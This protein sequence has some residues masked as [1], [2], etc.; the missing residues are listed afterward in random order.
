M[1]AIA[2]V[3]KNWAIGYNGKLLVSIPADQR[4]FRGET[5]GK[6]VVLGRKTMDTFP[7][8]R[9]LKGRRNII[10]TRDPKYSIA[11]AETVSSIEELLERVKNTDPEEVYVIGGQSVYEQ[12]LPYCD[13]AYITK[14]NYEYQADAYFP[15]LDKNG[16]WECISVSEEETY[17]DLEFRFCIYKR[18]KP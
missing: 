15:D 9:P 8:G 2:A 11:D 18:V 16:E 4:F 17:W 7:G 13:E 6:T 12:L 10:L 1:R 3:D 14:I 5:M